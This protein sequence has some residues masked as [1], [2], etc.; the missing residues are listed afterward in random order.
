MNEELQFNTQ[1]T[2]QRLGV[3]L[4]SAMWNYDTDAAQKISAAE[5]GTNGLVGVV[6]YN[7]EGKILFEVSW[8]SDTQ[9]PEASY[10]LFC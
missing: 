5:L 10:N 9:K 6:G 3:T 8:N 7:T 1:S 4:A 2:E